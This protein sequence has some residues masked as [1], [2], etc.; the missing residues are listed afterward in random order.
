MRDPLFFIPMTAH[1]LELNTPRLRLLALALS[2]LDTLIKDPAK[3]ESQL[4]LPISRA[5]LTPPVLGALRIKAMKMAGA[6][7]RDHPWYTYWLMV[8][9]DV[10]FGAGLAGFKGAPNPAGEVEIGYGIDPAYQRHGYTTETV[11]ALLDWAFAQP[12]CRVVTAETNR[13][14]IASIRVLQKAGLAIYAETEHSYYWQI[15]SPLTRP[16]A[17]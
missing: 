7:Q 2:H 4:G 10:S 15:A 8:V 1:L 13:D 16:D 11:R 5:M 12:G 14:N 9:E 17:G 3:L 6:P